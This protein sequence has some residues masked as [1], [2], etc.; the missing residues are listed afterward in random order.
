MKNDSSNPY[1]Y[2]NRLGR[3]LFIAM[4]EMIGR[5][6]VNA[7][8]NQAKLRNRINSYPKNTLDKN[9]RFEEVSQIQVALEASYGIRGGRG[10]ALRTGRAGFKHILHEFGQELEF[11]D[12]AFRLL[13]VED[14]IRMT[15]EALAKLYN[16]YSDQQVVVTENANRYLWTINR[17]PYCW[18]RRMDDA[19]CLQPVGLL[20]EAL[21]WVSSGKF[22]NIEEVDCIAK[23]D[24]ACTIVIDKLPLD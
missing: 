18:N 19:V 16:Q 14:K 5:N 7:V 15:A 4:E 22:Y 9:F 24:K 21:Y 3:I 10:L 17:C 1:Y 12:L 2:P 23:G 8:L 11:S 13:P 20:Q 6:G